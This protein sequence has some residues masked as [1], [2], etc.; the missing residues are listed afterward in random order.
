MAIKKRHVV[1]VLALTL[2]LCLVLIGVVVYAN[3]PAITVDVNGQRVIFDNQQP[4]IV[5]G[6]TLV[7]VRGVFEVLGFEVG[8]DSSTQR[9]T[10][11]SENYVV[12]LTIGS[13]VFTTNGISHNLDVPA[14]IIGGSTMLPIRAVLESVGYDVDWN[15]EYRIVMISPSHSMLYSINLDDLTFIPESVQA[16]MPYEHAH[17]YFPGAQVY[18]WERPDGGVEYVFRHNL[19]NNNEFRVGLSR[20]GRSDIVVLLV[21]R[22]NDNGEVVGMQYLVTDEIAR[23]FGL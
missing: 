6:R 20:V 16:L 5:E 4:A 23:R 10:L 7:P 13:A 1:M 9:V 3:E 12:I 8:F 19:D 18:L 2:V 11:E 22:L 21:T 15:G 14:R 17:I